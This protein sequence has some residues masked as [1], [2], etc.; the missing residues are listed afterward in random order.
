MAKRGLVS[1]VQC[2]SF[3]TII[4]KKSNSVMNFLFNYKVTMLLVKLI[5]KKI[6]TRKDGVF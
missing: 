3:C 2:L 1:V 5:P 6:N 4:R